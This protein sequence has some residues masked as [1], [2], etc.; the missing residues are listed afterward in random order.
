MVERPRLLSINR[1]LLLPVVLF[2]LL[3]G[4]YLSTYSGRIE[5]GDTLSLFD[6][7]DSLAFYGDDLLDGSASVNMPPPGL[8]TDLFP[9]ARANVEPL[10]V[11]LSSV[12][13]RT[14][15]HLPGV[16]SVH[17][18]WLL[19]VLVSAA[20]AVTLFFYA[21]TLG[22][23]DKTAVLGALL[24]GL[25]T[26]VWP[27]SKTFFREPL[28]LWMILLAAWLLERWRQTNYRSI[29]LFA[30]C[31]LALVGAFLSKE[32][33][34]L[35]APTLAL[36]AAPA[37]PVGDKTVRRL[38]ILAFG[39]AGVGLGILALGAVFAGTINFE[40]FYTWI[41][42]LLR[43]SP[44][45]VATMHVALH[46]YLLSIGGSIWATSPVLLLAAPGM[47]YMFRRG[48]YRYIGAALLALL[49]FA[50]GYAVFRGNHWFG[51]LSW[52]P[53]FLLPVVPFLMLVVLP[54]LERLLQ[55]GRSRWLLASVALLA[56]YSLWVQ[57]S[58][59]MLEWGAYTAALPPESGGLSEWGG[60]LNA[61]PY[62]R[63]VVIPA[64]WGQTPLDFAWARV[65]QPWWPVLCMA[66]IAVSGWLLIRFWRGTGRA[67]RLPG[68]WAAALPVAL[69]AV[70]YA[71]LRLLD[72][73]PLYAPPTRDVLA[74][75]QP[76]LEAESAPGD[77]LLLSS[78][79]YE[80]FFL[81]EGLLTVPRVVSLPDQPGEQPSPEQPPEVVSDN[82]DALLTR[83][84]IAL[85]YNLAASRERLWLLADS[86]PWLPWSVR[87]VERFL[88]AHYYPVRE[89]APDPAVRLIEY[90]TVDAPNPLD[91]RGPEHL[92]GLVY[93]DTLR[94]AGFDLPAG[95]VYAAG[96][97]LPVSFYWQADRTPEQ[98]YIVA[99]F[100][101]D[102]SGIPAV[103][104]MD[105]QPGGGF[106]RTSAW[107]PGLPIWD[108]RALRL[109]EDLSPGSYRLWVR[110]YFW[111]S[112]EIR[113][114]PV[115]A[116]ESVETTTGVLP[117]NIEV[118]S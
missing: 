47:V 50:L 93:G 51:G 67:I 19:N 110:L 111:D 106:E 10:H 48:H 71:G 49:S 18:A 35:A 73:D 84:S 1:R 65:N 112:G 113:L 74:G 88:S 14:A 12:L 75:L 56:I 2:V 107:R 22:Y 41:G 95:M 34:I 13:V 52:P 23:G 97:V 46:T 118:R 60:G 62:L 61:V 30:A 27:Y 16:G 90:S 80:P 79:T 81:N 89:I 63:W 37:L 39:A 17:A 57:L 66:L 31:L 98:D 76:I 102:E 68:L 11:F 54:A 55:Q 64:L 108:N 86:G 87:P 77:V 70:M 72:G 105:S 25:A 78:N 99:W 9:L 96:D 7:A 4:V 103:Q 115:T 40:P 42:G 32:A 85:I 36:I 43:R 38:A 6:A 91:F 83:G 3:A 92:A 53:R 69:A 20:A 5:S 114:L 33:V 45:A 15:G 58:G 100:V 29:L 104:G 21:L 109:P 117:V 101:V 8:N 94:L 59:V 82:P 28:S 24:F 116:G 44:S 26:I